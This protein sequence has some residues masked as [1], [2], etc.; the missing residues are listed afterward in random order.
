MRR[1]FLQ[2]VA[3]NPWQAHYAKLKAS[4]ST[5]L[6]S[7]ELH[8]GMGYDLAAWIAEPRTPWSM[9]WLLGSWGLDR[10]GT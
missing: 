8:I 7:D 1:G 4:S 5:A 6:V 2:Q 10:P 9:I 3:P